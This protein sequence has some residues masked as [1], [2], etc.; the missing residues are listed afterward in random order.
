M[1]PGGAH[2]RWRSF[3]IRVEYDDEQAHWVARFR[4][5]RRVSAEC[6]HDD[7]LAAAEEIMEHALQAHSFIEGCLGLVRN[8]SR[9]WLRERMWEAVRPVSVGG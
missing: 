8:P 5:G 2:A 4:E 3:S 1:T 9:S 7:P 6:R